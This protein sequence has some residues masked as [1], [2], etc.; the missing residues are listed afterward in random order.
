MNQSVAMAIYFALPLLIGVALLQS[1]VLPRLPMG[2]LKPDLVLLLVLAWGMLRG[3]RQGLIW[4]LVGGL[5]LDVLSSL[6]F[7]T[8]T[9]LL[10]LAG[11]LAGLVRAEIWAG[12]LILP[13]VA[14]A[15]ATVLFDLL[16]LACGAVAGW[17]VDWLE[18]FLGVALPSA[19]LNAL[20]MVVVFWPLRRAALRPR[21]A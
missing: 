3:S 20:V 6:P 17:P 9:A 1:T 11:L 13:V 4:G 12:H 5:S 14:A 7:G 15:L 2:G 18:M 19:G 10:M 8:S 16:G 21:L